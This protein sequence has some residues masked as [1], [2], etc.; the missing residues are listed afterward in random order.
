MEM[1]MTGSEPVSCGDAIA[2]P[3]FKLSPDLKALI[4]NGLQ[5]LLLASLA[6]GSYV[7]ISSFLVRSVQV[8]GV[9][10]QPTLHDHERCL[11]NRWIFYVREP[12]RGDIV[13]IRDP[14]DNG[15]SVKRVVGLQGD[16]IH[17]GR[18]DFVMNGK[19][20]REAY[21]PAHTLTYP[22]PTVREQDIVCGKNEY[23]VMGDNRMNSVDSR[24]YGPVPRRK[25]LGLI[26]R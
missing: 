3:A 13:V 19:A 8:V 9:S 25:V 21:L 24:H 5:F 22:N 11:L 7:F 18:G 4:R 15:Y 16:R 2:R 14:G 17:L 10:M 12:Q 26:V 23:I 6:F 1:P 20:L